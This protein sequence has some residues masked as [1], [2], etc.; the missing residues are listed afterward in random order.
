MSQ[1][2]Y[3]NQCVPVRTI[4]VVLAPLV[5]FRVATWPLHVPESVP[6]ERDV[7]SRENCLQPRE[8]FEAESG[9]L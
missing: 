5:D 8:M 4:P 2:V 9:C 6:V 1:C 7:C 3:N